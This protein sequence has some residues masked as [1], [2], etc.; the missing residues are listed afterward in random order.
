MRFSHGLAAGLFCG[1]LSLAAA[2]L[3]QK[4]YAQLRK[5]QAAKTRPI[6]INNDGSDSRGQFTREEFLARRTA[7]TPGMVDTIVYCI[8]HAG[9][10]QIIDLENGET[11]P[12]L[13]TVDVLRWIIDFAHEH[14]QDVFVSFRMNDV[15]D[16]RHTEERPLMSSWK[17]ANRDV[18]FGKNI[19]EKDTFYGFWTAMDHASPK[20]RDQHFAVINEVIEKYDIDGIDLDFSRYLPLF[21]GVSQGRPATREEC[22]MMT[23]L[24]RRIRSAADAAGRERG[25]VIL[26]SVV[27]P[28]SLGYCRDLGADIGTWMKEG[29]IDFWVQP[30][31]FRLNTTKDDV[32]T[33]RRYGVRFVP[34]IGYPYPPELKSRQLLSRNVPA[35]YVARAAAAYA[36]GAE[37]LIYSDVPCRWIL[38]KVIRR[39]PA[40]F[41]RLDK[42]YFVTDLQWERVCAHLGS[43]ERYLNMPVVL[44]TDPYYI[45]PGIKSILKLE[46]GNDPE[47]LDKTDAPAVRGVIKRSGAQNF[48]A[49]YSNGKRWKRIGTGMSHEVFEI[50]AGALHK[51]VNDLEVT[52]ADGVSIGKATGLFAPM[53]SNGRFS[54]YVYRWFASENPSA[55]T[56]T[57]EGLLIQDTGKSDHD[58]A[59]VAIAYNE[60]GAARA[61]DFECRVI[62]SDDDL[63]VCARGSDGRHYETVALRTDRVKLLNSKFEYK[64]D[65][66]KFHH[67]YLLL[68]ASELIFKIDGKQVFRTRKLASCTVPEACLKG[69]KLPCTGIMNTNAFLIGSL[70]GRGS[71]SAVWKSAATG[72]I[73]GGV[74]LADLAVE[75]RYPENHPALAAAPEWEKQNSDGQTIRASAFGAEL[76]FRHSKQPLHWIVSDGKIATGYTFEADGIRVYN[77]MPVCVALDDGKSHTYQVLLLDGRPALYRD[78]KLLHHASV[79]PV[80]RDPGYWRFADEFMPADQ[81]LKIYSKN[82]TTGQQNVI[83]GGGTFLTPLPKGI[84]VVMKTGLKLK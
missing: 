82:F 77:S 13:K 81:F 4:E 62:S 17:R 25:R 67:Y 29:L 11:S 50:P 78:G 33:A 66:T 6:M 14:K 21:K 58:I 59:N 63:A 76:T 45:V 65:A 52:I 54:R 30:E 53:F 69:Y 68:T 71:G 24:I 43:G 37:T 40:Q 70:S 7:F 46:M 80:Y 9:F 64:L 51:G 15:H 36:N 74:A 57:P 35:A 42:T 49:I 31:M 19:R 20:V 79:P 27:L 41:A 2:P 72:T 32:A 84:D 44:P 48:I 12:Y 56:I 38:E 1:A 18:L 8:G 55:E 83:R 28:D 34:Q 10:Q 47:A 5:V 61:F 22:E 23:D 73:P 16:W 60:R 39:D 3:S 75:F 26:I